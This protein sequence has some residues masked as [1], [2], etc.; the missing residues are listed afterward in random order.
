MTSSNISPAPSPHRAVYGFSIY[1]FFVSLFITYCLWVYLPTKFLEETLALHYLP[2]KYFALSI[3]V[4]I[5]AG[6]WIF[7][8]LIYPSIGLAMTPAI[9]HIS[10]IK[11]SKTIH[12]CRFKGSEVCENI[13]SESSNT[14]WESQFFCEKH[15]KV[16][17]HEEKEEE[18]LKTKCNHCPEYHGDGDDKQWNGSAMP[19]ARDMDLR[20]VCEELF[21]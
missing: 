2:D 7:A 16:N 6:T 19:A 15:S 3:P 17:G 10:T 14:C 21:Q 13:I 1:V 20:E 18:P 5:L 11:D 4:I 8:F 12:R 9:D